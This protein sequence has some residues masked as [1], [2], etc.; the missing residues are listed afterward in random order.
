MAAK[1]HYPDVHR[2][3]SALI[4]HPVTLWPRLP[5][6][7]AAHYRRR[8]P[9]DGDWD[10]Y[11]REFFDVP[12]AADTP[13][14]AAQTPTAADVRRF[15]PNL[16]I[17]V[18]DSVPGRFPEHDWIGR[19]LV[20]GTAMLKI[21]APTPRCVMISHPVA[22]LPRDRHL[23]R[24]VHTRAAHNAGVYARVTRPGTVQTGDTVTLTS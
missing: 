14:L 1:P 20:V 15:R 16:F 13:D 5:A 3:L 19:H 6:D 17:G 23:L 8:P 12:S 9:D 22:D 2:A 7:Q 4:G 18:P 21:T 24:T 11:L 10:R